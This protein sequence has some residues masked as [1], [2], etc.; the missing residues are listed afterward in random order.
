MSPQCVRRRRAAASCGGLAQRDAL[1]RIRTSLPIGETRRIRGRPP[2]YARARPRVQPLERCGVWLWVSQLVQLHAHAHTHTH[3]QQLTTRLRAAA[4]STPC[5][6]PKL[7]VSL[8]GKFV[9]LLHIRTHAHIYLDLEHVATRL[10][11]DGRELSVP[12]RESAR[13]VR[14][15]AVKYLAGAF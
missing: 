8:V 10:S 1:A 9:I 6:T 2:K 7:T 3:T 13:A 14:T 15:C 12:A 5:S 11:R 4:Y